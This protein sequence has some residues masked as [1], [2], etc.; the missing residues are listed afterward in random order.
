[1]VFAAQKLHQRQTKDTIF[2]IRNQRLTRPEIEHYWRRK[3]QNSIICDATPKTP[4]GLTYRTPSPSPHDPRSN[5]PSH[6]EIEPDGSDFAST[7]H[8]TRLSRAA[9]IQLFERS[10]FRMGSPVAIRSPEPLRSRHEALHHAGVYYRAYAERGG[11][12]LDPASLKRNDAALWRFHR[13]VYNTLS[14]IDVGLS[15]ATIETFQSSALKMVPETMR[16]DRPMLM[17]LLLEIVN[18][19][20]M[21]A[22]ICKGRQSQLKIMKTR[23]KFM[24]SIISAAPVTHPLAFVLKAAS[25]CTDDLGPL[26]IELMHAGVD[27][28]RRELGNEDRDGSQMLSSCSKVA[29]TCGDSDA[30]LRYTK[31]LHQ[32]ARFRYRNTM[33]DETLHSLLEVQYSLARYHLDLGDCEIAE[34]LFADG[35][36]RCNDVKYSVV[37][38]SLRASF[39]FLR[40][41]IVHFRGDLATAIASFEEALSL[42]L[43]SVGPADLWASNAAS[44]LRGCI[45]ERDAKEK[46]RVMEA[47][48]QE[49]GWEMG[50]VYDEQD[51]ETE[52]EI[53]GEMDG[54]MDGIETTHAG[55]D[56]DIELWHMEQANWV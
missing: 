1:M 39:L 27:I 46:R 55:A 16:V 28:I 14:A 29:Y 53:E 43:S 48:E 10:L 45:E 38:H 20:S 44:W 4:E 50:D 6:D 42:L 13:Q 7:D 37:R 25:R 24:D 41:E 30:A 34:D 18:V 51:G 5:C 12:Q 49:D 2:F 56:F 33:N 17:A 26:C 22:V 31:E 36:M 32:I 19:Y 35:L 3:S 9:S 40:G 54:E 8:L 11:L 23:K 21:L 15:P 47:A 52:G